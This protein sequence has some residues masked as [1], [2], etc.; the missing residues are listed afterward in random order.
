[1]ETIQLVKQCHLGFTANACTQ[2]NNVTINAVS[3]NLTNIDFKD[4]APF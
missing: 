3:Q 2:P 4:N 1:M